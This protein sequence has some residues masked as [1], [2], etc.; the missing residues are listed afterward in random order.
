M[1]IWKESFIAGLAFFAALE[2]LIGAFSGR[3]VSILFWRNYELEPVV[4]I[5][6]ALIAITMSLLVL[7]NARAKNKLIN[8]NIEK[9]RRIVALSEED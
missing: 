6:M 9:Y 2:T 7:Y 5:P 1:Y 3:E 8:G 4:A